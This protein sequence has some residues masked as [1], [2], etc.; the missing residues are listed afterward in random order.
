[1]LHPYRRNKEGADVLIRSV[2]TF[3]GKGMI[4]ALSLAGL[5]CWALMS[6]YLVKQLSLP[7]ASYQFAVGVVFLAGTTIVVSGLA[8]FCVRCLARMFDRFDPGEDSVAMN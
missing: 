3:T 6:S 5:L 1:M 2:L 4:W 8:Y 7:D